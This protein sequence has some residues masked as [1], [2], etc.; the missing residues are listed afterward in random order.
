LPSVHE[1]LAEPSIL[2]FDMTGDGDVGNLPGSLVRN[3]ASASGDEDVDRAWDFA[4][5]TWILF[6]NEYQRDSLDDQGM[7]LVSSVHFGINFNNAFWNGSQM[8]YGDGDGELFNSFT[9]SL[10]VVAH[11]LSHGVVQFSGGL[12]Y[13][14]QSGA[15]N[16]HLAD[17]FGVLTEQR[18]AGHQAREAS[19]L[20]GDGLIRGNGMAL[21]SL[22]E[23]G[24]AYDHPNLGADPQ[25]FH[26]DGFVIT[27]FDDGG[28]HINSGIPNH[29]FYLAAMIH[30]GAAWDDIGHIWYAALQALNNSLAQFADFADETVKTAVDQHGSGS[31]QARLVARAWKL[32]GVL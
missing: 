30:G 8:T 7:P 11:E 3:E 9:E 25:P 6:A 26:M 5:E 1:A 24:T 22:A 21:R 13:E 12:V 28:V 20:I 23:P 17:V 2:V 19:W 32:V 31:R 15:L 10:S 14:G 29:A 18:N 16:E 4:H 27:S